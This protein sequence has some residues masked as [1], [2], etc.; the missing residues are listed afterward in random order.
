VHPTPL[1]PYLQMFFA[2]KLQILGFTAGVA[3][4]ATAEGSEGVWGSALGV[5]SS[6]DSGPSSS[7]V[8]GLEEG[9]E[10]VV[11]GVAFGVSISGL[12]GTVTDA[13]L[14]ITR[15]HGEQSGKKC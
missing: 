11:A 13:L 6:R 3:G 8:E 2:K 5:S 9:V 7:S 14:D 10:T 4:E 1:L 15:T 12:G